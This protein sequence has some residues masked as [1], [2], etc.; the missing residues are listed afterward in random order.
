MNDVTAVSKPEMAVQAP[1]GSV[2]DDRIRRAAQALLKRQ[3]PD[4][5]WVFELEADATIPSEYILLRQFLGEPDDRR[6]YQRK[7]DRG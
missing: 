6:H 4:G 2:L 5:H 3:R 7:A 1:L